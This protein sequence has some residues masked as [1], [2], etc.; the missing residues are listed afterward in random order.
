MFPL[1]DTWWYAGAVPVATVNLL[2]FQSVGASQLVTLVTRNCDGGAEAVSIAWLRP[3]KEKHTL[4]YVRV[5]VS[6]F[7]Q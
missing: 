3:N 6:F 1:T 2:T 5:I 7:L 4:N